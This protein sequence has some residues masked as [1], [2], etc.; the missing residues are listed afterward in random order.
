[1]NERRQMHLEDN[2]FDNLPSIQSETEIEM[3]MERLNNIIENAPDTMEKRV[4]IVND[5][6]KLNRV[7][8][9]ICG[10]LL[11]QHE[12]VLLTNY[13][14]WQKNHKEHDYPPPVS[15]RDFFRKNSDIFKFS[16]RTAESY[17]LIRKTTERE[18]GENLG[19][20]KVTIINQVKDEEKKREIQEKALEFAWTAD[21]VKEEVEKVAK[22]VEVAFEKKELKPQIKRIAGFDSFKDE[23][24]ENRVI[25]E[26]KKDEAADLFLEWLYSKESQLQDYIFQKMRKE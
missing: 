1:M 20:R 12:K 5:L 10:E 16:F 14:N 23:K 24:K 7:S 26:F 17:I 13:D 25:I 22:K 21:R 4:A 3:F 6:H 11:L 2:L 9:W 18:I 8:P 15:L 19:T